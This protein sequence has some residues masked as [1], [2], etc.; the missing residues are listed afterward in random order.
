MSQS[1][2]LTTKIAVGIH[3]HGAD[4]CPHESTQMLIGISKVSSEGLGFVRIG[5][6]SIEI[7]A[8]PH[9]D[10]GNVINGSGVTF[11]LGSGVSRIGDTVSCPGGINTIITGSS[12]TYS[13]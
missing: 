5:D 8:C 9:G 2:T 10:G 1:I 3:D 11:A 12:I 4:C 7:G 6:I 13:I